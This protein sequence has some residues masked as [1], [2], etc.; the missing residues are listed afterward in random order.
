M[1]LEAFLLDLM[2]T[3]NTEQ[4]VLAQQVLHRLLTEI[5]GAVALRI[6]F[7][8]AIDCLLIVHG[9]SPHQVTEDAIKRDLLLPLDLVDLVKLFEARRNSAVH[10]Q[11]LFTDVAS[12]GHGIEDLHEHVIDL[13]II[14]LQ[15]FVSKSERF[16]H[17]ARLVIASQKYDI[18][19]EVLLDGE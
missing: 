3:E 19:G 18:P 12:N 4:S 10:R 8:I 5:V 9:V 14:P 13:N 2:A 17:V 7:E 16:S 11:V 15:H 6:F 1:H